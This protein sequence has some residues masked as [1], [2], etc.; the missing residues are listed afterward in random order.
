MSEN[1]QF[2]LVLITAPDRKTA[3]DLGK[4]LVDQK[5]AACVNLVPGLI[6]IYFWEGE[7]QEDQEMLLLVKTRRELLDDQLIPLVQE[8]HPYDLPEIIG[9][10]IQA[11]EENYLDWIASSVTQE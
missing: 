8:L 4:A 11:G 5:I 6:S 7:V 3:R 10:P 1:G 2:L 9:L